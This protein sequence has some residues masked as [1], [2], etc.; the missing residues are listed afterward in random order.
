MHRGLLDET[1]HSKIRRMD[2]ENQCDVGMFAVDG[3]AVVTDASAIGRSDIDET[4]SGFLHDFGDSESAP[5][6]DALPSADDD[7]SVASQSCQHQHDRRCVVV[8]DEG[9]LGSAQ[10]GEEPSDSR[11]P[12]ASLTGGEIE[13]EILRPRRLH[14]GDGGASEI[15]VRNDPS[16]IDDWHQKARSDAASNGLG[17]R[18]ITS[19][20]GLACCVDQKR[21]RQTCVRDRPR[22]GVDAG[23]SDDHSGQRYCAIVILFLLFVIVPIVELYTIIRM[24]GYIGFLNTLGVMLLIAVVGSWLVKREGL[25][26]WRRF[27]E[28]VAAGQVPTRDIVDGVLI[29]GAGALLLTPGFFSDVLGLLMLFPPTR[30]FFRRLVLRKSRR[31]IVVIKRSPTSR[32]D[33]IDTDATDV[34]GDLP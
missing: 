27:N 26:V 34:R 12:T 16:C 19:L 31:N 25:R 21:M 15:R 29:L 33:V 30:A 24:S 13:L 5:D 18:G 20:Y 6:F 11:L 2:L 9:V 22:E 17:K 1:F 3:L 7:F 8:D 4:R 28:S 14:M 32:G 23:R 10:S